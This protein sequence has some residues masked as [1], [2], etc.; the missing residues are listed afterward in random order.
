ME[1]Y[2]NIEI[3]KEEIIYDGKVK[4]TYKNNGL[5]RCNNNLIG[6]R[7]YVIFPILRENIGSKVRIAVDEILNKGIR[8][9]NRNASGINLAKKYVH[10]KCIVILGE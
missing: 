4:M 1:K 8:N 10:R 7:A 3:P 2:L 5:I 6:K 9:N